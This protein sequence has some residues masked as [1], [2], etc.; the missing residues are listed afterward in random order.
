MKTLRLWLRWSWR[1]L[2]GRWVQVAAIALIIALGTGTYAGMSS[3]AVWR[4]RSNDASYELTNMYDFRVKLGAG[5]FAQTGSLE[6]RLAQLDHA[7]WIEEAEERLQLATQIEVPGDDGMVFVPGRIVG[8][9]SVE[10]APAVNR[11]HVEPGRGLEAGDA[12]QNVVLLERNFADYYE[13]PP[14][15]EVRVAGGAP[16]RYVGHGLAPEYFMV[17][18]D[19]GDFLAQANFG[20]VF[21]SIDTAQRLSGRDD[22][23]NDLVLTLVDSA[24]T[25]VM[26]D[27]L[28]EAFDDLG[29]TVM[30][31]EDDLSYLAVTRDPEGDRQFWNIFGTALFLGAAFAAF[32]LT[33]RMVE[34]QRR[35]IG[36]AMA[37]GAPASRVALRPLLVGAQIALLG[38][39]FGIGVGLLIGELMRGVLAS[40]LPLPVWK[41]PFQLGLFAGV[42]AAGFLLPFAAVAY[43]VWRAVRVAPVDAIRTGHLAA[44]GG[45]LAPLLKRLPMPGG[46]IVRMPF[47]NLLRAP[48]RGLLTLLGV[49]SIITVLVGVVG[50]VDSFIATIDR[51]EREVLGDSP[52]RLEIDLDDI[53]PVDSEQVAA[54]LGATTLTDQEAGLRLVGTLSNGDEEIDAFIQLVDLDS[55]L[56]RP[57][58]VRGSLSSDAPGLVIA[59][60]AAKDLGVD[61]GDTVTLRHPSSR[62]SFESTVL[63]VIAVHPDPLRVNVYMDVDHAGLMGLEGTTNVIHAR[64][65]PGQSVDAV[66]RETFELPGVASVQGVA[67]NAAIV[68]ELMEQWVGILRVAEVV[69]LGLALLIA[70]NTASIS[71]DERAR[72]YATMF[73]YGVPVRTVMRVAVI[74]SAVVGAL[75]AVVGLGGG[76]LMLRWIVDIVWPRVQPDLG[77]LLVFEPANLA[78][79]LGLGVLA[80]AAAPLLTVRRLRRMDVPSTLRVME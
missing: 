70:F 19:E 35:E 79:V 49:A 64:P 57:T 56:W 42:A 18:T 24:D 47:R 65:A 50:M 58:A 37:L 60:E 67:A 43:P 28:K 16:A 22:V 4:M 7:S 73:A 76:Y 62:G 13:L 6:A 15:G 51:G 59:K 54:V 29:V 68:R 46:S 30:V 55:A 14:E 34:S 23:V 11:V 31:P 10:R 41:T 80:V 66:K 33:S 21:T 5:S 75:A 36:V 2:R 72:E 26:L 44:R 74:E 38:V 40:F 71:A 25:D 9:G 27:E 48:R 63:P 77:V 45:G 3:S 8:A 53:Y 20:V 69:V 17:V 61:V 1:D 78:L 12:G 52:D 39:V 32:N